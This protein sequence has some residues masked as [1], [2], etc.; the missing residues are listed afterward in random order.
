MLK[1]IVYKL[2]RKSEKYT[3]TDM[4]YLAKGGFWIS[5]SKVAASLSAFVLAIAYANL[6]PVETYATY[7]YIFSIAGLLSIPTLTGI[8]TTLVR[9]VTMGFE[10]NYKLSFNTKLRWGTLSTLAGLFVA[11][12]YFFMGNQVLALGFLIASI[13]VPLIQIASLYTYYLQGKKLFKKASLLNTLT[14][15][16]IA[17]LI[18][19]VIFNTQNI[20]T[21]IL[22]YYIGTFIIYSLLSYYTF[23]KN[24][25]NKN[26]DLGSI[27][28]GKHLSVMNILSTIAAQIDKILM[29]HLLGPIQL[30][31]YSFATIPVEQIRNFL[32]S[33]QQLALPKLVNHDINEIKKT[34]PAKMFK[35]A[36]VILPI[37]V[38]Y[39]LASPWLFKI[40]F[41][42]YINSINYSQI[43]SISLILFP[44]SL[45]NSA[46]TA[47]AN[48]KSLY[49]INTITP[50]IK[51]ISMAIFIPI[52]G[53]MGAI[54]GFI[55]SKTINSF[56]VMILLK[57]AK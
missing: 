49:I 38:I 40:F 41:P 10:G 13:F 4:V 29:W 44:F 57:K 46:L 1:D 14:S 22:S 2:L 53:I 31:I 35:F 50:I 23:R 18:I 56:I 6:L 28:L 15:L 52:W 45:V 8:N 24:K 9:S 26:K 11:G 27:K 21:I 37:V 7:K 36:I 54:Y 30:A 33:S 48:K 20:L 3:K 32:K 43:F 5:F 51:I 12:Y 55:F 19:I 34:L 39:Y 25:L 47:K 42:E 17:I 16:L